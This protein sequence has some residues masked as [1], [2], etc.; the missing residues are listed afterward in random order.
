MEAKQD[1]KSFGQGRTATEQWIWLQ[2]YQADVKVQILLQVFYVT[3]QWVTY[4]P[5]F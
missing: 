1:M 2:S 3:E 5:G 4:Y